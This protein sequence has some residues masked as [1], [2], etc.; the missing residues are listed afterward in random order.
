MM[1]DRSLEG[2]VALVTGSSRGIG[3]AIAVRLGQHGANVVVNYVSS[4]DAAEQMAEQIRSHGVK[5]ITVKANVSKKEEIEMLFQRI[6]A[7]FGQLDIVISNSGVEHFGRLEEVTEAEIDKTF[8]VNVKGQFFVAQEAY[9]YLA[10]SG[11]LILTS[12][13]AAQQG[14]PNHSIYSASKAAVQG[15]VKCLAHDFAPRQITV[16]AIAPGGIKTDMYAEAA[17]NYFPEGNR[18]SEAEIEAAVSKVSPLNRIGLPEDVAGVVALLSSPES[19]WL[20]G[21][22]FSV[23]GGAYMN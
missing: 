12:S 2:K 8:N 9:K 1:A 19:Q 3:S 16:N 21:Q 15:L 23:S 7:E 4:S 11:R 6:I 13:V 20:T 17:A 10:S 14:Y 22:T 5:A 18:M